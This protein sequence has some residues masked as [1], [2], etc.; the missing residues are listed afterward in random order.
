MVMISQSAFGGI[1]PKTSPKY[2][3]PTGAQTALDVDVDGD[4]VKPLKGFGSVVAIGS[5]SNILPKPLPSPSATI[6]TIYRFG[7]SETVDT[8]YWCHWYWPVHVCRGQIAGDTNEW[9]FYTDYDATLNPT[10]YPKATNSTLMLAAGGTSLQYPGYSRR[11][12]LTAP[13]AACTAT[14]QTYTPPSEVDPGTKETRVYVYTYVSKGSDGFGPILTQESAPSAVSNE[15]EVYT[16][17]EVVLSGFSAPATDEA[18]THKRIYRSVG[19]SFLFVTELDIATASFTDN[20]EVDDAA[21]TL[22]TTDYAPPPAQ[23]RGMI[24]LPN[25]MMA[26]HKGNDLYF[27]VPYKPYAWPETYTQTLDFPVVGLGRTD[28]TLVA[29]TTGT[30]YFIQGS[31]PD[32]MTATKADFEQACVSARSIVSR[33]NAVI[34]AS[35]DGLVSLAPGGSSLLTKDIYD[36]EQWQALLPATLHAY[37]YENQYVAFF[38]G[39]GGFIYDFT[40]GTFTVHTMTATA[41]YNDLRNDKLYVCTTARQLKPWNEGNRRAGT[42]KSR[43]YALPQI[44]GFS[45]AQVEAESYGPY[46]VIASEID[47]TKTNASDCT[48]AGGTWTAPTFKWWIDQTLVHTQTL[49]ARDPFRLPAIQ[50]RDFEYEITVLDEVTNVAVAQSMSEIATYPA[51]E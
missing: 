10:G 34:Y 6:Q 9:T 45:C 20:V 36:R 35:P 30:P 40:A 4:S 50:G 37:A 12:G 38:T 22:P 8:R 27:C 16:S 17:Q 15:V 11:L 2:L 41:G 49:T 31:A 44:T 32:L 24:N 13:A 14:P 25:G 3:P 28:T 19:G 33:R 21:E 43:R 42:F 1:A 48:N 7:Q 18:A 23:L 51:T 26:G 46:C 47:T 29:L 39:G 5:P